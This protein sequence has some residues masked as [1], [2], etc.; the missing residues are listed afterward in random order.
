M[1]AYM[2]VEATLLATSID[3]RWQRLAA[4]SPHRKQHGIARC[5]GSRKCPE[6]V[7]GGLATA[8]PSG[9]TTVNTVGRFPSRP[10]VSG[11]PGGILTGG[12]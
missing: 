1:T 9:R 5:S 7:A 11:F 8:E 4:L 12:L 3:W 6:K 10:L 2:I